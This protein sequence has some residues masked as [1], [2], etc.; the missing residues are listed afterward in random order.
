VELNR[1]ADRL[2]HVDMARCLLYGE[3]FEETGV[4]EDCFHVKKRKDASNCGEN[5]GVEVVEKS[6][7]VID[8][9]AFTDFVG[10][11]NPA[12]Y[13]RRINHDNLLGPLFRKFVLY[14]VE[15][16]YLFL[17]CRTVPA[18][19]RIYANSTSTLGSIGALCWLLFLLV[20]FISLH[21]AW[22]C[23]WIFL[24]EFETEKRSALL[25]KFDYPTIAPPLVFFNL[26]S[27][28]ALLSISTADIVLIVIW[29]IFFLEFF[30]SHKNLHVASSKICFNIFDSVQV[31][32]I[33]IC[34]IRLSILY[35]IFSC[36]L[37]MASWLVARNA[38]LHVK[39]TFHEE[40]GNSD[41]YLILSTGFV[42]MVAQLSSA[43]RIYFIAFLSLIQWF[44]FVKLLKIADTGIMR[45]YYG[46]FFTKPAGKF[47]SAIFFG[48]S[49][50]RR[51]FFAFFFCYY[52]TRLVLL[53][54]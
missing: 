48:D 26:F 9:I 53:F 46:D 33:P 44:T 39:G 11:E 19:N 20:Q 28:A 13:Y 49:Y 14:Q 38:Y 12:S 3:T 8:R 27:A 23:G 7:P 41:K 5:T 34:I 10:V 45:D 4:P 37:N 36:L 6:I 32:A 18:V 54:M 51:G 35:P 50:V 31:I 43:D 16:C 25:A 17:L 21:F 30:E 22:L 47:W 29:S 1:L 52:F 24:D 42:V 40:S 15:V 2:R